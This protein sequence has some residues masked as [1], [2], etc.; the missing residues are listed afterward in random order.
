M[1]WPNEMKQEATPKI[2]ILT[3][4]HTVLH[5]VGSNHMHKIINVELTKCSE[6]AILGVN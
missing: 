2:L 1:K 3:W 5:K 6:K 4:L